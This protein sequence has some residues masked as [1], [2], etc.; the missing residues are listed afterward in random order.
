MANDKARLA[1]IG[2]GWWGGVLADAVNRGGAGEVVSG[3]ARSEDARKA[4]SEKYGCRTAGSLDEVWKD[5]E[6]EGVVVATPHST[7]L[8]MISEAASAGKHVFVEKPLTL[9]V[10]EARKA[11]EATSKAGVTLQ[12]GHHRRRFGANRKIKAM[13]ESGELG[14]LHQLEANLSLPMGF[15]PKQGWR[16]DAEECPAG[17]MT[18]LGVHMIDNLQYLAGPARRVCA[19]SKKLLGRTNLD[20]ATSIIIE[21]ESGPLGSIGTSF[22]VPKICDTAAFGTKMRAYSVEEGGRLRVAK[23]GEETL[24]EVE[25]EGGDALADEMEEFCRCVRGEAAPETGG[26][27]GLEVVA[28][29]ESVVESAKTGRVVEVAAVRG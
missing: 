12:V 27:E 2:L 21:Y 13:I 1:S 22:V 15:E 25:V 3:F 18:G 8:D 29:L 7:H 19:F 20:D 28:V 17:S 5:P 9:T 26:A 4:F 10:A 24:S 11:V 14:V 23:V 6:V 16:N